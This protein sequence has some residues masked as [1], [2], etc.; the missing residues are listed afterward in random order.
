MN[1]KTALLLPFLLLSAFYA[2]SD[3]NA[4]PFDILTD[5]DSQ[6]ITFL[7]DS[8]GFIWIGTF[9]GNM[10]VG[11]IGGGIYSINKSTG[12]IAQYMHQPGNNQSILSNNIRALYTDSM[13]K[14]WIGSEEGLS[15][16]YKDTFSHYSIQDERDRILSGSIIMSILEDSS[17]MIWIGT[18]SN[19]LIKLDPVTGEIV[20]YN[21]DPNDPSSI[22]SDRIIHL[23]ENSKNQLWASHEIFISILDID[24]NTFTTLEQD[25]TEFFYED[26]MMWALFDDGKLG[27]FE[28]N[29]P[30][31]TQYTTDPENPFALQTDL[32]V[33]IFEDSLENIWITTLG[34]LYKFDRKT[35]RFT[36][37]LNEPG[38]PET[39]QSTI[40]YSPGLFEDSTGR[41][42]LGN[43]MPGSISIFDRNTG[44]VVK[45]YSNDPDNP[46]SMPVSG[47]VN[48]FLED[49]HNPDIL[50][51]ATAGGLIEFNKNTEN[52]IHHSRDD[53]W[54][55]FQDD[56][57]VIWA[58][59]W[60]KGLLRYDPSEDSISYLRH[61]PEDIESI[62]SNIS[63][64][65]FKSSKGLIWVGAE[66]G[67][68]IFN[69]EN[70][71][72]IS[73]TAE[74]GFP[75][76]S[77]HSIGEDSW[78]NLWLG[79]TGGLV[80]FNHSD[81]EMETY[82]KEDGFRTNMFYARNGIMDSDGKMWF[83][84]TMGIVNFFP[85][86]IHTNDFLPKV[87]L[88]GIRQAGVEM[89]LPVAPEKL[90]VLYLDWKD[91]YFEFEFTALSYRLPAKNQFAYK[92]EGIDSDWFLSGTM[93]FGRYAGLEPGEYILKLKASNNDGVWN[94]SSQQIKI[95]VAPPFWKTWWFA[96]V[97]IIITSGVLLIIV[98][99]VIKL[100]REIN[101]RKI[102]EQK[103]TKSYNEADKLN[104]ELKRIDNVKD[105]FLANTSHELR[106]P[107]HGII[108][109]AES[110]KDG[111]AGPLNEETIMNISLITASAKR[112]T[113]LVNDILD[114]SK[115]RH[116]DIQLKLTPV[117][118]HTVSEVV[119]SIS[120]V[121]IGKKDLIID[122]QIPKDVDFILGDEN[123]VQQILY[124]LISNGIKFTNNGFIKI[125]S[126]KK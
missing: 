123:R 11:T 48:M 47:Q 67:L 90:E 3:E 122:N 40:N 125:S 12:L 83:G 61:D 9:A 62:S 110:L 87:L 85:E 68:N 113:N 54:G 75:I 79:T 4:I 20:L 56:N 1:V 112:L 23:Y 5:I 118:I 53:C 17:G 58:V 103:L 50:W 28:E 55:V 14:L 33:S 100:R 6:A 7:K 39:I 24:T 45:T 124:N 65:I 8:D 42:W 27:V 94:E 108:G 31:F 88:T 107:L 89:D 104:N 19:G 63:T 43:A 74:N 37:Y 114:Y 101:S 2:Y 96:F 57:K 49:M 52:F 120:R 92:L 86:Q 84:G 35:G 116:T 25:I 69:P 81:L 106:T 97:I 46:Y 102:T 44:K 109:I 34:G 38:N 60:G 13:G 41:F 30:R 18:E 117:D 71:K 26:E 105:E 73:Y 36:V 76:E 119:I 95:I 121:L 99:Y 21:H 10:W 78:G 22:A 91:N 115:L 80:K 77:V 29:R 51:L 32:V 66:N 70:Q 15:V 98:F 64:A 93:N 16:L 72:F 126:E 59:T 82:K 111:T